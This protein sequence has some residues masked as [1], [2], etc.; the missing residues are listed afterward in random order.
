MKTRILNALV[1]AAGLFMHKRHCVA[2][3]E[4]SERA[5]TCQFNSRSKRRRKAKV[6]ALVLW[7]APLVYAADP[8]A[9]WDAERPNLD[10]RI[11]QPADIAGSAYGYRADR[12]ADANPPEGWI[13]L[14]QYAGLPYDKPVDVK[15]PA[16]RRVLRGLLWEEV[17]P[18]LRI[19][20]SWPANATRQPS[21]EQV[22][23]TF[24]DATDGT[25]HTWWNPRTIKEAGQPQVSAD[26]RTYNYTIPV[27]TW[28]VV[29]AVRGEADASTFAV[30]AVRALVPDVWKRMEV[31]IEWGFDDATVKREYDGRVEAYDGIISEA[32]A[33]A[34]DRGTLMTGPQAWRSVRQG[35]ARRGVRLC[36]LYMGTSR[37][38]RVWPYHAQPE[39]VARTILTVWT[40][41]GSFSFQVSDLEQGPIL[42]PEH[43][44]FVRATARR[45]A[46]IS[47]VMSAQSTDSVKQTLGEKM[48][49][50]PGVPKV[51]GWAVSGMPWF[52]VNAAAESG[53]S[54]SLT[55]PAR[56]A[57]MHPAPDR[58][59]AV[60]WRSPI[61]GRV[62]VKGSA[63]MGDSAGGNGIQWFVVQEGKTG[64]QVLARGVV[65]TGGSQTIPGPADA[66]RLTGVPVEEGDH[67]ALVIGAKD[68]NHSC[69]TTLVEF[70]I[71]EVGCQGRVWSLA[72]DVLDS[73]HAGNPHADG[74]GNADVWRFYAVSAAQ[75]TPQ[76]AAS[77]PPFT[78][79]SNAR[80]AK[81]FVKELSA[82]SRKTIRQRV[83]EHP[84]QTWE[85]AVAAM[86]LGE[87]LPPHPKPEFEPAMQ[88]EVPDERLTAQWKLGAWHILR[89]SLKDENGKWHFNDYPFGILASE[90]YMILRAL[91]LQGMHKEAADGL[92]Q[93]LNL[94]VELK[95]VPGSGGHHQWA[96]PDR[97]LGHFSEGKGCLTHAEGIPGAGGHMDGVHC[98]GP[99]AI[100]FTLM[101]HFRLTGDLDWLRASAPRMK[102]NAEWILRQRHLLASNL[103]GG[104]RLWSKGLQPAHVVTPDSERMHMQFYESEAYYW[105]A[106]KRMAELLTL[107]D[108]QEGARMAAEAEAYRKDLLA[109]IDHSIALTPVVPVRDGTY[110]SFIPFSPYVRG[111]AAGAWG[112]RRCQGHIGAIYW[113][114][115]QSADPLISPS[116]LL[117]PQDPR[118]QGHLDVLEDRLLLENTKVNT[119]T[120]GFDPEK[121]WFSHASW[122]YQCGLERHA[123]IH[124][125]ADD[126]PNFLR[127]MLNQY[128]VDIMPG[129]YTFRE[130]TTGGPPDK[131]Y[132]ESCF[133]ER[134][135][136]MLVMEEGDSLWLARATPRA[137]LEPGRKISVKNAPTHFGP[138]SYEIVSGT[139]QGKITASVELPS[140]KPSPTLLLRFR[141]PK[142]APLRSVTVNG[143]LWNKFNPAREA[144][145]LKELTGKVTVTARY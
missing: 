100:M 35:E 52:G 143:N 43:G 45:E 16:I 64:R 31:E 75:T 36:V 70:V 9:V 20:L 57:A 141:H 123:N 27:D 19:E 114:T 28:G 105:L 81:D 144:I 56:S 126:V 24:F 72:K 53:T 129:E 110:R 142:A 47:P 133:L 61:Q 93:W 11:G 137:W 67:L 33:L 130:H 95:V 63:A 128:A 85:G 139:G 55:V 14:M 37:W 111:F 73:I 69:D 102:A 96:R 77:E 21:P 62:S 122:Q 2:T 91:D 140:G 74:L 65:D 3:G 138:V 8:P 92:D 120:T 98:M 88:V 7:L 22:A 78:L 134:F 17:R 104:Q 54:G 117:S 97:P 132:E 136:H 106:V 119:R 41:S 135:R 46:A 115:V 42:A 116:G 25:A 10:K 121:H 76:P 86:H 44:F 23:L 32:R 39:D 18:V 101:E 15:A 6:M 113:D 127:S 109:A 5:S 99:G 118:V 4:T 107:I 80:T 59:V 49:S 50:I 12:P 58:D 89:R 108:P 48:D 71:T 13:L 145:E 94:P 125:A 131:I 87:A 90:T 38:R 112:W 82:K 1:L 84:E 79:A 66:P 83:R 30:P 51:R 29:A 34:G 40:K 60:G 103:P 124:L 26:G 68:G